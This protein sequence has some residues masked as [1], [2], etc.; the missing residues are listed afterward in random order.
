MRPIQGKNKLTSIEYAQRY[1]EDSG[2]YFIRANLGIEERPTQAVATCHR[3]LGICSVKR[4]CRTWAMQISLNKKASAFVPEEV[5]Y[6]P[7]I[8]VGTPY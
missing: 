1:F 8:Q 3:E 2:I 7:E 5:F 6:E 4:K